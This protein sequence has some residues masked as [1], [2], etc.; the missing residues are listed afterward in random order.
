MTHSETILDLI[1]ADAFR[2]AYEKRFSVPLDRRLSDLLR[3][4]GAGAVNSELTQFGFDRPIELYNKLKQ[5]DEQK[6]APFAP[7]RKAAWEDHHCDGQIEIDDNAP[8]SL[9]DDGGAYVQ[10]WVW[11]DDERAL[12]GDES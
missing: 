10:A 11:V 9:S 5:L 4:Y 3:E 7:Y 8:V 2:A 6:D 12:G 1:G